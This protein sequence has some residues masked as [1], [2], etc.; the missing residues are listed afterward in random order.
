MNI[1]VYGFMGVGKTTTGQ[2]LADA[3]GYEFIDMDVEIERRE[4]KTIPEIF[5]EDGEPPDGGILILLAQGGS[6]LIDYSVIEAV[7]GGDQFEVEGQVGVYEAN[8]QVMLYLC[9]DQ[10]PAPGGRSIVRLTFDTTQATSANDW[11]LYR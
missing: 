9:D 1:A 5:S 6:A 8:D 2:L 4:G 7:T 10:S 3:L 11:A